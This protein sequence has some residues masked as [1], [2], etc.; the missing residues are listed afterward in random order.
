MNS[1]NVNIWYKKPIRLSIPTLSEYTKVETFFL[2]NF[3]NGHP[4]LVSSARAA[5]GVLLNKFWVNESVKIFKYAS[6]CVV[7][8]C[9]ISD[10]LPITSLT[11]NEDIVYH[12]WGYPV[13]RHEGV[14]F[15]EDAC[16]SFKPIGS[17]VLTLNSRFEV[18]SLSKILGLRSGAIIWCRDERDAQKIVKFRNSTNTSYLKI[19]LNFIRNFNLSFYDQW[20]NLELRNCTLNKFQIGSIHKEVVN[21]KNLFE[22]RLML[23]E[24]RI[25]AARQRGYTGTFEMEDEILNGTFLPSVLIGAQELKNFTQ[26]SLSRHRINVGSKP[27]L[28]RILPVS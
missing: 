15:L 3:A 21:W 6:Q 26:G 4:V 25:K 28:I 8:A 12:Q 17:R 16:D 24:A 10:I 9:T 13:T 19:I 7:N 23:F 5:I 18:W 22:N 11:Q 1:K 27:H 14:V 2:N 20:E